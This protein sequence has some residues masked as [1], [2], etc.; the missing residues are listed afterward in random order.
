MI[1][2]QKITEHVSKVIDL[3]EDEMEEFQSILSPTEV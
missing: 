3:S 2:Y 1:M